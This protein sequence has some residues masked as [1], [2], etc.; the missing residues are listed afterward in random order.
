M[1]KNVAL[2]C[3]ELGDKMLVK[4]GKDTWIFI[5]LPTWMKCDTRL[6]FYCG[7]TLAYLGRVTNNFISLSFLLVSHMP[8]VINFDHLIALSAVR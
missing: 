5:H 4:L 2:K 8:P 3:N 6:I 7:K 1:S